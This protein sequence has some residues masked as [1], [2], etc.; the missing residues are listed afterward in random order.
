MIGAHHYSLLFFLEAVRSEAKKLHL[1]RFFEMILLN[2]ESNRE[3]S[4]LNGASFLAHTDL[5]HRI[6][7]G[8]IVEKCLGA[9]ARKRRVLLRHTIA[10]NL[11]SYV[12]GIIVT[13]YATM[14]LVRRNKWADYLTF[15]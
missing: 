14:L 15:K 11:S 3:A 8:Q 7:L 13:C 12:R 6:S 10:E 2:R 1:R 5:L 4:F 9:V